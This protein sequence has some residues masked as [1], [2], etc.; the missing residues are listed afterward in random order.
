MSQA[1]T[2]RDVRIGSV[3]PVRDFTFVEDTT[4]AFLAAANTTEAVG[5]TLNVGNGKGIAIGALAE[6]IL[7]VVGS[8][9]SL[10]TDPQRVRPDSSEVLAL[11]A[12]ATHLHSMTG[13]APAVG[14][15]EG[16]ERTAE[17]MRAQRPHTRADVYAV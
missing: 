7:D 12:D 13:W 17:W 3:T 8:D 14:L 6:L 1:L 4:S 9:A 10:L 16:L 15:R 11:I 5:A 2:G